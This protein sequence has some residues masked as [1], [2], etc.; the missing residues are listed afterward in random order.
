MWPG[1]TEGECGVERGGACMVRR[2]V[3]MVRI[4]LG[5][6]AQG[7]HLTGATLAAIALPSLHNHL[8]KRQI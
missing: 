1:K 5:G 7:S 6:R 2:G 4:R 3:M 8:I